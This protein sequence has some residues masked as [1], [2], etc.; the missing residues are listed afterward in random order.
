MSSHG[1]GSSID[2]SD[3]P[4][5]DVDNAATKPLQSSTSRASGRAHKR[6]KRPQDSK[7]PTTQAANFLKPT[8]ASKENSPS[9]TRIGRVPLADLGST[10]DLSP[11]TLRVPRHREPHTSD[12]D[13]ADE[14][15]MEKDN[16]PQK[17]YSDEESF[18]GG[19]V[20]TSTD[21]QHFSPLHGV[22]PRHYYDET[23][24][25]F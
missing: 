11:L 1:A 20:F 4:S 19:D 5:S 15:S 12:I 10:Q 14:V 2:K 6:I 7:T 16:E 24:T 18:G 13:G 25:D 22:P 23:I 17:L 9:A 8:T 3:L 21:Q